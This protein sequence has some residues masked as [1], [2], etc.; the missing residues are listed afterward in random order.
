M[1]ESPSSLDALVVDHWQARAAPHEV[2]T[3]ARPCDED[4][5][6]ALP[7]DGL[8]EAKGTQ[9]DVARTGGEGG[10]FDAGAGGTVG[11]VA[12]G[13]VAGQGVGGVGLVNERGGQRKAGARDRGGGRR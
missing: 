9:G 4:D 5:K 10:E 8:D 7:T 2:G 11:L 13:D 3:A 12:Q 1:D 6:A